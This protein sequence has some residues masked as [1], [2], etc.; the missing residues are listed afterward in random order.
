M[1]ITPVSLL[2]WNVP[3]ALALGG[4][5]GFYCLGRGAVP[6]SA[7]VL[8]FV[9]AGL[10]VVAAA[11]SSPAVRRA[12]VFLIAM[13]VAAAGAAAHRIVYEEAEAFVTAGQPVGGLR[14]FSG[15]A[16]GDPYVNPAGRTIFTLKLLSA[17]GK[18]G[19]VTSA[20][21]T[22]TVIGPEDGPRPEFGWG[23]LCTVEAPLQLPSESDPDSGAAAFPDTGAVRI[24]GWSGPLFRL[25]Y[26][27]RVS[28]LGLMLDRAGGGFFTALFLGDRTELVPEV[29]DAFR[30][31]GSVHILALSGM[32]LAIIALALSTVLTPLFGRTGS[33]AVSVLV[34]GWYMFLAGPLP[35]LIRAGIMYLIAGLTRCGH[36]RIEPAAVPALAFVLYLSADPAAAL[37]LSFQLSF[38][39]VIGIIA[40][41]RPIQAYLLP[42]LPR[43]LAGAVSA[44][45][46]AQTATAPLVIGVFGVFY[47]AGLV[48][49][50]ALGPLVT[51]FMWGGMAAL[52]AA[53]LVPG[54]LP[55]V[56]PV[57]QFLYKAIIVIVTACA[58]LPA[59]PPS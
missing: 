51:A 30:K 53:P 33:F 49:G 28:L 7:A 57:L 19:T 41:S 14:G 3:V 23:A 54:I 13:S 52:I 11:A 38:L 9:P 10:G 21:G 35:S 1:R 37:S 34:L 44:S 22:V 12:G 31:A 27:V 46:A 16:A 58:G 6:P 55:L 4:A 8:L 15:I 47:P 45:I 43:P 32:H 29:A 36:R 2:P 25:R 59:L 26:L 50:L 39:A 56:D 20:R 17:V 24:T 5:I 18:H 42:V 48:A 40:L